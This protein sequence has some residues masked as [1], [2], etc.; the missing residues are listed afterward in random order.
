LETSQ[1]YN[2]LKLTPEER[3][4][5]KPEATVINISEEKNR[6]KHFFQKVGLT[7]SGG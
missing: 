2:L 6:F 4:D 5:S 1:K 3:K 7:F